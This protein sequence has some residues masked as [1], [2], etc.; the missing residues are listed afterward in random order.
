[1]ITA[2]RE[3]RGGGWEIVNVLDGR[4]LTRIV[5]IPGGWLRHDLHA[6]PRLGRP[7]QQDG[8]MLG[9]PPRGGPA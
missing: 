2:S 9:H 6:P 4:V 3:L 8:T 1:M 7:S 5:R